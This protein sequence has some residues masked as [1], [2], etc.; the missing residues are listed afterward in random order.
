MKDWT[1]G[2]VDAALALV[3]AYSVIAG[4]ALAE[5]VRAVLA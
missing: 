1:A 4:V 5:I 2:D 3:L